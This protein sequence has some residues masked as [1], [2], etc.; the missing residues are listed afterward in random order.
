MALQI[1]GGIANLFQCK[2]PPPKQKLVKRLPAYLRNSY[3][4]DS[5][6]ADDAVYNGRLEETSP[7]WQKYW[8]NWQRDLVLMGVDPYLQDTT[9][10]KQIRLLF[11]FAA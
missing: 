5:H 1:G 3:A 9:F 11:G 7:G 6:L 4:R 10:S 8:D 2:F